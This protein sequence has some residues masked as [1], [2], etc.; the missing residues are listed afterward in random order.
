MALTNGPNLN[1]LVDGLQGEEH[2]AA[3][4]RRWRGMDA[5]TQASVLGVENEP[6]SAPEDGHTY[7]VGEAPEE[8]VWE[9][10]A[11]EIARW[12]AKEEAWEFYHP[13]T[14]WMVYDRGSEALLVFYDE[15]W[16]PILASMIH[17]VDEGDNY[18]G[19]TLEEVLSEIGSRLAALEQTP[20]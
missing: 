8:G 6:P 19:T 2:Y 16:G 17:V 14:G 13:K 15:V 12:S 1:L 4:M 20:T 11:N 10:H 5:L 3:L 18:L 9:E 7:I